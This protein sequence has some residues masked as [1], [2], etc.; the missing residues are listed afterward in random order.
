MWTLITSLAFGG[1]AKIKANWEVVAIGVG[2]LLVL[3]LCYSWGHSGGKEEGYKDGMDFNQAQ[4][5]AANDFATIWQKKYND[6]IMA[7]ATSTTATTTTYVPKPPRTGSVIDSISAYPGPVVR[8]DSAFQSV[9]R[10]AY[11]RLIE[12]A[13][14]DLENE[15]IGKLLVTFLPPTRLWV[16][17]H[18]PPPVRVD[19]V[20][21]HTNT[22]EP[23]SW[24]EN[25]MYYLGVFSGVSV[26][27]YLATLAL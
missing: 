12:P 4:V 20:F 23:M 7:K 21:I 9:P 6:L 26:I 18:Q 5:V 3:F 13:E 22:I 24:F 17:N 10:A 14:L 16:W 27:V 2:V 15:D 8:N 11:D 25:A 19:S 1:L